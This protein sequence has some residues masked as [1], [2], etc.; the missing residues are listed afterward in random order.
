MYRKKKKTRQ[1]DTKK[2]NKNFLTNKQSKRTE[3]G[4]R[5]A[6]TMG[7]NKQSHHPQNFLVVL[8]DNKSARIRALVNA[9]S[10]FDALRLAVIR[11]RRSFG[12]RYNISRARIAGVFPAGK[13]RIGKRIGCN[14][15]FDQ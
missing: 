7:N 4:K 2:E 15:D 10:G 12:D 3:K 13:K 14:M 5:K 9:S 6:E 8:S 1:T 11:A